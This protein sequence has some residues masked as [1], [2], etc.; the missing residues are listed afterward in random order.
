MDVVD[1]GV[2]ASITSLAILA[3]SRQL[4]HLVKPFSRRVQ[5]TVP[6]IEFKLQEIQIEN[7][8]CIAPPQIF[9]DENFSHLFL[10]REY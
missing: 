9:A 1:A 8:R 5:C 3:F 6:S 2:G 10:I 4:P 7:L